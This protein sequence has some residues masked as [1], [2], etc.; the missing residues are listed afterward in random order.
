MNEEQMNRFGMLIDKVV[1]AR[2]YSST[3]MLPPSI[4]LEAID[5]IL[6]E[7][8]GEARELYIEIAGEDPWENHPKEIQP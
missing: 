2:T 5:S 3:G 6:R 1:S 8:S 4:C 7:V